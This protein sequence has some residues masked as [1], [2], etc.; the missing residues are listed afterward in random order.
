MDPWSVAWIVM[1]SV[2][3]AA[4]PGDD[5]EVGLHASDGGRR[6]TSGPSA[7]VWRSRRLA[8]FSLSGRL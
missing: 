5:E 6:G 2:E 3:L 1:A 7:L 8:P 4:L